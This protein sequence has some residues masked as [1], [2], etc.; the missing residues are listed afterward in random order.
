MDGRFSWG[1]VGRAFLG[2]V[3]IAFAIDLDYTD[4]RILTRPL[5][6]LTD[7]EARA[8]L[9]LGPGFTA[10]GVYAAKLRHMGDLHRI[11]VRGDDFSTAVCGAFGLYFTLSSIWPRLR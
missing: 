10:T 6:P 2:F 3:L 7:E 1:R 5:P 11:S 4:A 9:T 8:P